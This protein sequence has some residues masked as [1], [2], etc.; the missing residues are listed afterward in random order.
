[1]PTYLVERYAPGPPAAAT[2]AST[3][4]DRRVRHLQSTLIPADEIALCLFEAPSM[5]ALERAL[6]AGGCSFVRIVEALVRGPG[7]CPGVPARPERPAARPRAS[8]Q[9]GIA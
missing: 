1:V 3:D 5:R 6:A 7:D 2:M 8:I 9:G 4:G